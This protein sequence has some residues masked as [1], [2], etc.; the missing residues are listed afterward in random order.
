[1]RLYALI[2]IAVIV[3]SCSTTVRHKDNYQSSIA[4]SNKQ[5]LILPPLVEVGMIDIAG[6]KE[7]M[8]DY[9]LNLEDILSQ[10]TIDALRNEGF[11]IKSIRRKTLHEQGLIREEARMRNR[12]NESRELLYSELMWDEAKAYNINENVGRQFSSVIG[13][14][15]ETDLLI[16]IDFMKDFK[17]TGAKTK[18]ALIDTFLGT[19]Y[20]SNNDKS[21]MI[22]TIIDSRTGDIL[23]ANIGTHIPVL[24]NSAGNFL[25]TEKE[26]DQKISKDL[27]K[28]ILAPYKKE[29]KKL[30]N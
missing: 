1:M 3:S 30:N 23:W 7:R 9:E 27:L 16:M 11:R 15:N 8:Y 4:R 17:T 21:I 13:T 19:T 22:L 25:L 6:K 20:S 26:I 24:L 5:M 10:E 2:L 28:Q 29:Q 12:Y 18:D 14:K